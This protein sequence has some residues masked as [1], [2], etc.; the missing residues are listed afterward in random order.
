MPSLTSLV[1]TATAGFGVA[2]FAVPTVLIRVC[3]LVDSPDARALTRA[4]GT[5]DAVIGLAMVAAP[6]GRARRR[7]VAARAITDWCD[8]A[9]FGA[10]LAGRSTRGWVAGGAAAW[11]VLSLL[12]GELDERAGR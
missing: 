10:A 6:P 9:A 11:G 2:V 12:V 8:A 5:R 7:A 3:G 4:L 1:G